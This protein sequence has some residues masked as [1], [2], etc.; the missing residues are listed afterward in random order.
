MRIPPSSIICG[1]CPVFLNCEAMLQRQDEG[2][3]KYFLPG[4][5]A[6]EEYLKG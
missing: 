5:R 3:W 6:Y 1:E 4:H 2:F